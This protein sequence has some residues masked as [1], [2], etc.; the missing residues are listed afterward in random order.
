MRKRKSSL[1]KTDYTREFVK[2][3]AIQA[4]YNFDSYGRTSTEDAVALMVQYL[5]I[6]YILDNGKYINWDY[7]KMEPSKF[8]EGVHEAKRNLTVKLALR[9]PELCEILEVDFVRNAIVGR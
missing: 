4:I 5:I 2:Q 7:L 9:L 3:S 8:F 6:S 1:S